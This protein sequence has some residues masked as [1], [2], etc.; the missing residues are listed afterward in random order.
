MTDFSGIDRY[1]EHNRESH[2]EKLF[3]WLR[4][5]SVSANPAHRVD[6]D[7][8]A[9]WAHDLLHQAGLKTEM[10]HGD[11]P[12]LVYAETPP[13][14][15]MPVVLVYGHYDVQPED[16]VELWHSPPFEPQ[17]RDGNVYARGSTD[18][19]G[20]ALT[21]LLSVAAWSAA[22]KTLPLQVKFLLEGQEEQ[23]SVVLGQL[24]P[25]LKEKIACDVI[26]I[27]DS[28]Q[29]AEGQPAITYGLRGIA[30]LKS[31]YTDRKPTFTRAAS[32]ERS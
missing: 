14:P 13:V 27:S 23:G 20:Q 32:V 21:H 5:P 31:E 4:I 3:E 25:G 9:Q 26:V 10:I 12:S 2:L 29:Y 18:D 17:V 15:G 30:Y 16:P 24:L 1:L 19:K 11:G 7:R 22:G 8:A 28:S 6:M